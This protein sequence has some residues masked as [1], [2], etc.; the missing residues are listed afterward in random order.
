MLYDKRASRKRLTTASEEIN[1]NST[2]DS[3]EKVLRGD[4]R[5]LLR[6]DSPPWGSAALLASS[7]SADLKGRGQNLLML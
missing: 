4:I 1:N 3:E 5:F 2:A 7:G 6:D